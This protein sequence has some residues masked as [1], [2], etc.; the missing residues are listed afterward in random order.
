MTF[1]KFQHIISVKWYQILNNE[2]GVGDIA[3]VDVALM[4]DQMVL[5]LFF[6][7]I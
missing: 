7:V 1:V 4:E 2:I 5:A 6:M 3:P